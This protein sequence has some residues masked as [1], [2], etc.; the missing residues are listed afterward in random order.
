MSIFVAN[1]YHT[2][3]VLDVLRQMGKCQM[4]ALACREA[5][6]GLAG[7]LLAWRTAKLGSQPG[8]LR[9]RSPT[10]RGRRPDPGPASNEQPQPGDRCSPC[11]L[12]C[13]G[14]MR[15]P[16][17]M[18]WTTTRGSDLRKPLYKLEPGI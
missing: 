8:G 12:Q 3:H 11:D 13:C 10:A 17:V 18:V 7:A 4:A 15:C 14:A 1:G 9:W 6:D 16:G 5:A 2:T